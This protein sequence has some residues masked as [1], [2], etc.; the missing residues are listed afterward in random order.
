V[1]GLSQVVKLSMSDTTAPT[2]TSLTLPGTVNV[3]GSGQ[4]VTFTLGALD[5]LS[6]VNQASIFFDRQI[7]YVSNGFTSTY[8][9]FGF[10][11]FQDSFGDGQSL[12]VVRDFETGGILI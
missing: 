6:G 1:L 10:D 5:D 3:G 7:S 8:S 4:A 11:I 9:G 2:P 12:S